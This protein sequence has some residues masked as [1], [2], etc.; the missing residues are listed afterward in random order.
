VKA[1]E[2]ERKRSRPPPGDRREPDRAPHRERFFR[3]DLEP[4]G[5]LRVVLD[6]D[7]VPARVVTAFVEYDPSGG[8]RR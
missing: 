8:R 2:V 3:R 1:S 5:W 7:A 4:H 6:F